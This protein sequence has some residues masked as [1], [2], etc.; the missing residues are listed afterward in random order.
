MAQMKEDPLKPE[1]R[2]DIY[3]LGGWNGRRLLCVH[4]IVQIKYL[5]KGQ[6]AELFLNNQLFMLIL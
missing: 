3:L 4:H 6:Q 5:R 2:N 1:K